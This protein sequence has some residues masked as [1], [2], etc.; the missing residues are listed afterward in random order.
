MATCVEFNNVSKIFDRNDKQETEALKDISFTV[1]R[2]DIFGIVG[3]SGSGKSTIARLLTG[4]IPPTSGQI[5]IEEK[6]LEARS[7]RL[8]KELI[9]RLQMV[10][11]NPLES[12]NPRHTLG[13]G[14]GESLL[15]KGLC[16]DEIRARVKEQLILCGLT[17]DMAELYP[18]QVSGGQC[19]RA[20]IARALIS[21]PDIIVCDEATSSLD[22]TVQ[23]QI[24]ELLSDLRAK[25]DITIIFI[26]HNLPLVEIFCDRGIVLQSG[27]LKGTFEATSSNLIEYF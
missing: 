20:A 25:K 7:G 11:Q 4:L 9:G 5:L 13:Y 27:V 15:N 6:L 10:F 26:S 1:Q 23:K 21:D 2:G 19:Q 8:P 16:K 18:H 22:V 24:I 12:F 17:E 14:I 3:E